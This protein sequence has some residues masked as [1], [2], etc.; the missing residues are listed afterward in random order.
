LLLFLHMN[1]ESEGRKLHGLAA[2]ARERGEFARSLDLNDKALM[3][4]DAD[5][6]S[7]GFAEGIGCRAITLRVFAGERSDSRRFLILAKHEMMASVEIARETGNP[8]ALALPLFELGKAHEYLGEHEQAVDAFSEAVQTFDKHK[9]EFPNGSSVLADMKV[10][11]ACAEYEN[12]DK[13]ALARAEEALEALTTAENES[14]FAKDVW[15]SGAHMHIAEI[16]QEDNPEK[17]QEHLQK[18]KEIVD[19]NPEL[20]NRKKQWERLADKF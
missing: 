6:D 9:N 7:L 20:V 13:L 19:E 18:A 10:H 3:A 15:V 2:D 5:G 12:G 8:K 17:A 4:Y 16:L 14:T 1:Q 11:L